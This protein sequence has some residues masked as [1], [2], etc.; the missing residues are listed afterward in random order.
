MKSF[1]SLACTLVIFQTL[2]AG[3]TIPRYFQTVSVTRRN[4]STTQVQQ[5][6]GRQVFNTTAIFEPSDSRYNDAIV[7]W[8]IVAVPQIQVVVEPGQESDIPTIVSIN[9]QYYHRSP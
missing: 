3:T 8:N 6:L 5:E 1:I 7:R 2:G 4:L 9:E